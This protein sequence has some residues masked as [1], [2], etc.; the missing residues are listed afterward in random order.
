M[1]RFTDLSIILKTYPYQ[2]RDKIA[3]CLTEHHGRTTG[4]AKGGVHSRRFGGS[5]DFLACSQISYVQKP[6]AEMARID[7]SSLHHEFLNLHREF[8]RL[9]AASFSAEFC[10]KL[11]EPHAPSREM[12]LILSNMLFQLDAGM[13][14]K[15]AV[16]AFLCKSFKAMGYPPSLLRCVLCSRGAHEIMDAHAR[17]RDGLFHW[18]S[19]AGGMICHECSRGRFKIALDGE[20]L[21]YFHKLTM[22]P[23]RELTQQSADG[24]NDAKLYRLLAD[25]LHHHIPGLPSSGLKSWRLLNDVIIGEPTILGALDHLTT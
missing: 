1:E 21:L 4:L 10:L 13:D 7:E 24:Q 3:V 19:E 9:T 11:I 16:N 8:D 6:N 22:S 25:F 18:Y 15:L 14:V 20:T 17:E 23:F 2:E 12:F 5:L